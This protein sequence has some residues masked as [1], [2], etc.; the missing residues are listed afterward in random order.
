MG[1][2]QGFLE[3]HLQPLAT[4]Y[5]F[6]GA[7]FSLRYAGMYSWANLL[8]EFAA[9]TDKTYEY[10]LSSAGND[11]PL[12]ATK[13]AEAFHEV[14][15]TS[16]EY[17]ASRLIWQDRVT[18]IAMPLKI[19]I[20]ALLEAKVAALQ[21]PAELQDEYELLKQATVDG[22]ITTNYDRLLLDAFP[23]YVEFIGQEGL[24]FSDTQGIAEVYAIHGSTADPFSLVLTQADYEVYDGRNAYLAAKLMTIFVEHPVI[25]LGYS[26]NDPNIHR[27]LMSI[28]NGLQGRSVEKLQDRL[29]FVEWIDSG[30]VSIESTVIPISGQLLPITR[31]QTPD[32][33]DVFRA[34]GVRKHALPARTLRVLKEQVYEIVQTND[35]ADRLLAYADIDSAAAKDI[36]IVFGV[37]AKMA[38]VGIVGLRRDDI[39]ADILANPPGSLPA[40]EVIDKHIGGIPSSWWYPTFKYLRDAGYLDASGGFVDASTV[41]QRVLE[42]ANRNKAAV[43][44]KVRYRR[45][46]S[47]AVFESKHDWHWIFNNILEIASYVDDVEEIRQYLIRNADKAAEGPWWATQY[48]KG[49]VAYDLLKYG[50]G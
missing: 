35:P 50:R 36:S 39:I 42:R 11:L 19:E 16:A 34:L 13:I 43:V 3:R 38:A 12:T 2:V 5:L 48:Y 26:F 18:D 44:T 27:M 24:L 25:F 15:F 49:V 47:M 45:K 33:R 17:E 30:L 28:V 7:G 14:W 1:E 31:I 40:Q 29:V 37:G 8:R 9:K 20:A 46:S 4:P 32:W 6:V 23:D 10:Y 22:A 21:V 41:P